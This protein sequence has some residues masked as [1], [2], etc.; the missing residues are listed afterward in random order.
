MRFPRSRGKE[1]SASG[2]Q[3]LK[4]YLLGLGLG[5]LIGGL[6]AV[7]VSYWPEFKKK[8]EAISSGAISSVGRASPAKSPIVYEEKRRLDGLVMQMDQVIFS[9]LK[10]AGIPDQNINIIKVTPRRNRE[11]EW[12]Q[13]QIEIEVPKNLAA[14]NLVNLLKK[15]LAT[16]ELRPTPR[17]KTHQ[18]DA[19][20]EADLTLFEY[21]THN[22][23]FIPM[24]EHRAS[25]TAERATMP[26]TTPVIKPKPESGSSSRVDP[27][28]PSVGKSV[29]SRPKVAIVIDDFGFSLEQARCFIDL[30]LP[31]A[32]SVLPFQPHTEEIARLAHQKGHVVM[33][34]MPM[35]PAQWPETDAG[36]GALMI[37]MDRPEIQ[38]KSKA[39]LANIPFVAGVNNHM[40]S[41]FTEDRARMDWFFEEI[42]SRKLFFLD[43]RTSLRSV[44]FEEAKR[45][46]LPAGRRAIFLDNVQ[47]PQAIQMQLK[48]LA[49]DAAQNGFSIGIGHVYLV[50]CQVLKSEY[51]HLSSKVDFVPITSLIR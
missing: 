40:G 18:G 36:P 9:T 20:L 22:L 1:Q 33:L 34:H 23:H 42:R 43:S 41:R 3:R 21:P 13:A 17:I 45:M 47:E 38:S 2:P 8:A 26:P 10:G 44:A 48:K 16:L 46:G 32:V 29:N 15:S 35:Q 28:K 11:Q 31:L 7:V 19:G 6:V 12:E 27:V 51:N 25:E 14:D 49:A 24:A 4:I 5:L 30:D 50:T 39:A 37:S